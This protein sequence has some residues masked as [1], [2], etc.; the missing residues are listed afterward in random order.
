MRA[1]NWI[2]ISGQAQRMFDVMGI[3][4]NE[5]PLVDEDDSVN[6][7]FLMRFGDNGMEYVMVTMDER[8]LDNL[9]RKIMEHKIRIAKK[10]RKLGELPKGSTRSSDTEQ[11]DG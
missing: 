3:Y 5:S 4:F 1:T 6:R 7:L 2:K 11:R 8:E 10:R 9:R